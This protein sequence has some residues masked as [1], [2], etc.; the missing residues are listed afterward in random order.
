MIKISRDLYKEHSLILTFAIQLLLM[1]FFVLSFS[2]EFI[3]NDDYYIRM[4]ASGAFGKPDFH[5]VYINAVLGHVMAF[6]YTVFPNMCWYET[7]QYVCIFLSLTVI[8]YVFVKRFQENL[9]VRYAGFIAL[10][11]SAY[12]LYVDLQYTKTAFILTVSGY[13]LIAYLIDSDAKRPY[14]AM[15]IFLLLM[16]FLMRSQ[17]FFVSSLI[18]I[19]LYIPYFLDLFRSTGRM[20]ALKRIKKLI[21]VG[22]ISGFLVLISMVYDNRVYSGEW[23]FYKEYNIARTDLLDGGMPIFDQN[24]ELY[25]ELNL[26]QKDYRLF[27]DWD[28]DDDTVF[29]LD[30]MKT[31]ISSKVKDRINLGYILYFISYCVSYFFTKS[32]IIVFT[33]VLCLAILLNLGSRFDSKRFIAFLFS[34]LSLGASVL[35]CFYIRENNHLVTHVQISLLLTTTFALLYRIGSKDERKIN[36]KAG[37]A[38]LIVPFVAL[39]I[40][41]EDRL[42]I[43]YD[44]E[45][46]AHK[47]E[48]LSNILTDE[49]HLYYRR[50]LN[51]MFFIEKPFDNTL[52]PNGQNLISFGGWL[53]NYPLV[54][55][56]KDRFGVK[57]PYKDIINNEK[58]Y[59]IVEN[60]SSDI[61]I[62]MDH[63]KNHFDESV[64]AEKVK[65]I[66]E[67]DVYKLVSSK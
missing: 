43:R 14:Y 61:E 37:L 11:V 42:R 3:T 13:I 62:I 12:T 26:D 50:E 48:V 36:R 28:I 33:A 58:V 46:I 9:I 4:I 29:N 2:C 59:I 19:S 17:Q 25:D 32:K 54:L 49:Q 15:G 44:S 60:S 41:N 21:L 23:G 47:K 8:S 53:T 27:L 66:E 22:M 30:V 65:E 39:C 57:N 20:D 56:Q 10:I 34:I 18:S 51:Y 7:I 55:D 24:R 31:I 52:T 35:Y 1:A 64:K 5:L 63:I 40:L 45:N 38:I 16:G 6:L 67:Y